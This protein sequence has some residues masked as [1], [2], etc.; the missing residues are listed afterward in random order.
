MN[1]FLAEPPLSRTTS[2]IRFMTITS[3]YPRDIQELLSRLDTPNLDSLDLLFIVDDLTRLFVS[4]LPQHCSISI[5]PFLSSAS[6]SFRLSSLGLYNLMVDKSEFID[7]LCIL[8]PSLTD[9]TIRTEGFISLLEVVMNNV[10]KSLTRNSLTQES[11][12][13]CP[14]LK[15]LTLK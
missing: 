3:W 11:E 7:C 15:N 8:S 9:L 5:F 2:M 14:T 4:N 10:L 6:D 12:P 1:F 13:L